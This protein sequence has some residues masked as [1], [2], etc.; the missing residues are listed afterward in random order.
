VKLTA[1]DL[2]RID[3]VAPRGVAVG[4]RYTA[5]QMTLVNG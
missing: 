5:Q 1:D 4:D 2:K 3:A